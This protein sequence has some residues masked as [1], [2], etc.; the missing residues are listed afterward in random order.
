MNDLADR[1]REEKERRR[2]EI[3]AAAVHVAGTAGL[4]ALTMDQVARQARLSRA[5]IYVYFTDK[6]DLL[7]AL[8]EL[9]LQ[10][11]AAGFGEALREGADGRD[12]LA[13]MG[14]AYVRFS[15]D[16]PVFFEVLARCEA[17]DTATMPTGPNVEAC[18]L[19]GDQV[20]ELM[21]RAI[22]AGIEDGSIRASVGDADTVATV[23]WGFIHGIIQIAATKG[24][25]LERRGVTTAR[26]FEQALELA[27]QA[28]SPTRTP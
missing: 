15:V 26:L 27:L 8:C 25:L 6:D 1:R 11:L 9:A 13:R 17:R 21:L 28:L 23:L 10:R 12:R 24:A 2:D 19:R 20:H 16:E 7:F 3:L 5:L 22:R 14:S 4:D 18:I